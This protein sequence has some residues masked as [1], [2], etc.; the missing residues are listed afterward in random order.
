MT[1][2]NGERPVAKGQ[3]RGNREKKKPKSDKKD[4]KVTAPAAALPIR[5]MRGRA[6]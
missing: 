4:K 2:G 1:S 5:V 6:K 3:S